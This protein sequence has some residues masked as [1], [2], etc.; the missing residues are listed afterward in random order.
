MFMPSEAR[1]EDISHNVITGG[2]QDYIQDNV[3]K[4]TFVMNVKITKWT[5]LDVKK[6][7]AHVYPP[8]CR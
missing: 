3:E 5:K 8:P 4:K 7:I 2:M 1:T 6:I